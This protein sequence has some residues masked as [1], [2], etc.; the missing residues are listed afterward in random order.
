MRLPFRANTFSTPC[1]VRRLTEELEI[2]NRELARK[3]RLAD[4]G[5]MAGALLRRGSYTLVP[6]SLYMSM[7]RRS[8]ASDSRNKGLVEKNW[9]WSHCP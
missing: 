4:L 6:V 3:S 7:L 1:R 9:N 2:K 5:Q 8:V